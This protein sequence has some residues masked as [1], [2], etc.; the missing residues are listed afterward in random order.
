MYLVKWANVKIIQLMIWWYII[1][2]TYIFWWIGLS[3]CRSSMHQKLPPGGYQRLKLKRTYSMHM[4]FL[5]LT[6]FLSRLMFYVCLQWN[7]WKCW[8]CPG[9]GLAATFQCKCDCQFVFWT[10]YLSKFDEFFFF[11][12]HI[13]F[14]FFLSKVLLREGLKLKKKVT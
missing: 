9:H 10:L 2:C 13:L 4:P 11:C 1:L 12:S 5:L 8:C 14:L 7:G 6:S 3:L